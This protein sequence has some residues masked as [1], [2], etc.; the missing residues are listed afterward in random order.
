MLKKKKKEN[1]T[2]TQGV[3]WRE[4][5]ETTYE[6]TQIEGIATTVLVAAFINIFKELKETMIK[7]V[8]DYRMIVSHQIENINK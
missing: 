7:E 4:A 8:K 6:R 1:V 2:P 5:T 3:R